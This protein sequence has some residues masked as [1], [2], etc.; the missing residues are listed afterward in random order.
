MAA[1]TREPDEAGT[2]APTIV[3]IRDVSKIYAS[4]QHALKDVDLSIRRGEI[5]ALLGP[6][7]RRQDDAHQHR[8]RHRQSDVGHDRRRWPRHRRA[9]IAPRARRSV[10][11]RRSC[12]PTRSRRSGRPC[13]QPRP[14]RQGARPGPSREG[15]ARSLAVGEEGQQDHDAVGRHEAPRADREGAVARAEHPVPRRADRGRRRRA[16]PRHVA[17]W[18]AACASA[19]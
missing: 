16:A 6:Q 7:R 12:P 2:G 19:A 17:A 13:V 10:S 5:F 3:E 14:V 4:G 1:D 15:A 9:T 11:C 8:L 18:C